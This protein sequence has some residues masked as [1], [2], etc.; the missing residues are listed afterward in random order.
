MNKFLLFLLVFFIFVTSSQVTN[1]SSNWITKKS[2]NEEKIKEIEDMYRDGFLSKNEC[3]QAKEKIL[4]T[5]N[6]SKTN[7]D[8]VQVKKNYITIFS[9]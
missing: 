9:Y 3:V 2:N 5:S 7:C 8:N 4:K 6:F 1:A